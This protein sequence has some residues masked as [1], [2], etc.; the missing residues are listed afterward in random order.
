MNSAQKGS[1]VKL[2]HRHLVDW[3]RWTNFN[4][5]GVKW[6]KPQKH[7]FHISSVA[8]TVAL[9]KL[10]RILIRVLY[11]IARSQRRLL[12][13]S[14]EENFQQTPKI[15]ETFLSL[16]VYYVSS[17]FVWLNFIFCLCPCVYE[18]LSRALTSVEPIPK[19]GPKWPQEKGEVQIWSDF[20][21]F[22]YALF[23][24]WRGYTMTIKGHQIGKQKYPL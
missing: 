2:L 15:F 11:F 10:Q 14:L 8:L 24:F 3:W 20:D 18:L 23:V 19:A 22:L 16:L 17:S 4:G 13:R 7:P 6:S 12:V 5:R 1:K 9:H 21:V